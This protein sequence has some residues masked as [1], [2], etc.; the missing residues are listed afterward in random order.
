MSARLANVLLGLDPESPVFEF[1]VFGA[2]LEAQT[3]V[4]LSVVGA[5]CRVLVGDVERGGN[6]AFG[7][8]GGTLV[9]VV[10]RGAGARVY[11]AARD[12][13]GVGPAAPFVRLAEPPASIRPGPLRLLPGPQASLVSTSALVAAEW[14]VATDSDRV[15]LRCEGPRLG[16]A[17]EFPSEPACVGAVQLTPS[18]RVLIVGPDGP[19]IGGYPKIGVVATV[20]HPRLGQLRP[21]D[22]VG[23]EAVDLSEALGAL[24]ARQMAMER[25]EASIGWSSRWK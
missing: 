9:Q 1:T 8:L 22:P 2:T 3:D 4:A 7:V 18:G 6:A 10:G 24:R 16:E 12:I 21:G 17:P 5:D 20:D 13:E 25:L 14:R 15:G 19:T 23:F 11:V